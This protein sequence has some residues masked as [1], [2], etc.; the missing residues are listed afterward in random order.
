VDS[1]A[2]ICSSPPLQDF[3]YITTQ[4]KQIDASHL[5]PHTGRDYAG[6][7]VRGI[8]VYAVEGGKVV[9]ANPAGGAGNL[10]VVDGGAGKSNSYYM[11]L[12]PIAPGLNDSQTVAAGQLLGYVGSTGDPVCR[13]GPECD[14]A[15]LHFEQHKSGPPYF[16]KD[17]P[18]VP[19]PASR[20]EPCFF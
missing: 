5:D 16:T 4:Y 9:Y 3:W 17:S 18:R 12:D 2:R 13:S 15:H 14:P 1:S 19:Y 8:P 7:G 20:V 10:V 11:H 6:P